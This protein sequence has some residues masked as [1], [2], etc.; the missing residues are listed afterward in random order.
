[1]IHIIIRFLDKNGFCIIINKIKDHHQD[2][3]CPLNRILLPDPIYDFKK[4]FRLKFEISTEEL[5]STD[6]VKEFTFPLLIFILLWS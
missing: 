2:I 1:M 5:L 6:I 3:G 4:Y